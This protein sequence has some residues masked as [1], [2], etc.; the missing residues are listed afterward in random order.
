MKR[1]FLMILVAFCVTFSAKAF[2]Y[3]DARREAWF[4][5][6]KMAYELNLTPEQCDRAYE[7]NLEYFMSVHSSS[8]CFGPYWRYRDMDLKYVLFS[9]QYHLFASLDYFY[10]PIRWV[11]SVWY[12]PVVRHYRRGYYYFDRPAVYVSYRGGRW[13]HRRYHDASPYRHVHY[14]QGVGLRDRYHSRPGGQPVYH[15][16]YNRPSRDFDRDHRYEGNRR[17]GSPLT[18]PERVERPSRNDLHNVSNSHTR[19]SVGSRPGRDNVRDKDRTHSYRP[20]RELGH[21]ERKATI[22]NERRSHSSEQSGERPTKE[23]GSREFGR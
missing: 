19:P 16:E 7:I 12:Y 23:R 15:P 8:D 5:T 4:L 9:W 2:N 14:R 1:Y 17:P 13:R 3:E 18:R 10:R 21:S 11:H 22:R 6:D 20:S